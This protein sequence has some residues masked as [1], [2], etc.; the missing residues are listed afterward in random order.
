MIEY[1]FCGNPI[2]CKRPRVTRNGTFYDKGYA[3][4]KRKFAGALRDYF[5]GMEPLSGELHFVAAYYRKNRVA[6]DLDN[7]IKAT[8]DAVQEAGLIVND[9]AIVQIEAVKRVDKANP[10]VEFRIGRLG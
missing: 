2:P 9:S 5:N 7:L 8:L 6:V 1:T 3:D 10:R 4:Y